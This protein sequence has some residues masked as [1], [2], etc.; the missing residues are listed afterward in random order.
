MTLREQVLAAVRGES[1]D[2]VPFTCY[3]GLLPE[4]AH[5]IENLCLV[6]SAQIADVET[7]GVTISAER[8]TPARSRQRMETPWGVLT[9]EVETE[10]GYG[11]S[12]TK[13]HWV[14]GAEDYEIIE[15]VIR[16]AEVSANRERY[17]QVRGALGERGVI[18]AWTA[19]APLQRLWIEYTGIE[20]LAYDLADRPGLVERVLD[21]MLE[22]SRRIMQIAAEA[23][24][25]LI[26]LPDNITGEVVGPRLFEAYLLPYYREMCEMLLPAGKTPC[27]HMDGMLGAITDSIGRS[28]LPVIEA[29]TP[30]PDGTLSVAEA[31]GAWPEKTLWLNFPSSVHLCDLDE[32]ARVTR[33]LVR[34]AGDRGGFLIGVTEN[35]PDSV[36]ARSLQAIAQALVEC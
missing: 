27:C 19:R 13:E 3:Q 10:A 18:L 2:R 31:A 34:Q 5:D 28:P 33:S 14:K 29:F 32:I 36:G 20:R 30:P 22:Q 12:W 15:R 26:W 9:R 16:G 11:S 24:A 4:G 21:A 1:G 17:R 23:E 6:T 8:I 25:E 35:I 7:P